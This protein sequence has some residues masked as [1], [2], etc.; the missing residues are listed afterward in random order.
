[1]QAEYSYSETGA[2]PGEIYLKY[3]RYQ[4]KGDAL[5][6]KKWLARMSPS[7]EKRISS[8]DNRPALRCAFDALLAI[9]AI[10]SSGA[11]LSVW[12]KY[13]SLHCDDVLLTYP[14]YIIYC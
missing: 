6:A 7:A 10:V 5:A 8:L 14:V 4:A 13:L 11:L 12:N 2:T 1:M 3:R 9:P